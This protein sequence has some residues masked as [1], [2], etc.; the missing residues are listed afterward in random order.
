MLSAVTL[1]IVTLRAFT[2]SVAMLSTVMLI[3]IMTVL[4][5]IILNIVR[6]SDTYDKDLLI[7][8]YHLVK[9]TEDEAPGLTQ[10]H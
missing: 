8:S 5:D 7:L 1:S 10:K 3:P 4:S 2:F 9:A 6:L